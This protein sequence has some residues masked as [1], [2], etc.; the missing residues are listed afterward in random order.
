MGTWRFITGRETPIS[1]SYAAWVAPM[2]LPCSEKTKGQVASRQM[3]KRTAWNGSGFRSQTAN[4]R[5]VKYMNGC[6]KPC[7]YFHN[8][9]TKAD[10]CSFIAQQAFTAQERWRTP[11]CAGADWTA[12]ARSKLSQP[13]AWKPP[14]AC[15]KNACAGEILMPAPPKDRTPHGLTS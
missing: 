7:P 10:R 14:K 9:W 1:P 6:C 5:K 2:L 8:C 11:C 12:P 15:W 13:P 3:P 4:T